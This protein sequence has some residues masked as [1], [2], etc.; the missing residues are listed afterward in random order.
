[1][2]STTVVRSSR[3]RVRTA[4]SRASHCSRSRR[5]LRGLAVERFGA[6]RGLQDPVAEPHEKPLER[7]PD[8]V[9]VID[10]EHSGRR[11]LLVGLGHGANVCSLHKASKPSYLRA[12]MTPSAATSIAAVPGITVGHWTDLDRATG[13]TV[14]LG[15][16]AGMRAECA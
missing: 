14:V 8:A 16:D 7:M 10:H 12:P 2:S 5:L 11:V 4:T 1:M 3:S 15:P 13:C 9:F 6:A